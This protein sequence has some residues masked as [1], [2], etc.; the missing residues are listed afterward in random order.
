MDHVLMCPSEIAL[1]E[2]GLQWKATVQQIR[3]CKT[4][5]YV[6]E[7]LKSGIQQ[8]QENQGEVEWWH[9]EWGDPPDLTGQMVQEAV[10]EQIEIG[11]G[12]A[13]RDRLSMK[14]QT[15]MVRYY[16]EVD[17][18]R[19]EAVQRGEKWMVNTIKAL[20]EHS[21]SLWTSRIEFVH[22]KDEVTK[23]A[24]LKKKLEVAVDKAF[25][26]DKDD[27]PANFRSLFAAGANNVKQQRVETIQHWLETV[28]LAA[29]TGQRE[30]NAVESQL[31]KSMKDWLKSGGH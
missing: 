7:K 18:H 2:R 24:K 28:Q 14:W 12:Q 31:W 25:E 16:Q 4:P 29:D 21:C 22:G 27:V 8:W 5:E 20:W 10:D 23:R 19:R 15:A 13:L 30:S 6:I 26:H 11:W 9:D 1:E 17:E 3:R